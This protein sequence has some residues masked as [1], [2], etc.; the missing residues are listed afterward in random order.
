MRTQT[1]L[2]LSQLVTLC[3]GQKVGRPNILLFVVDDM[4]I[5]DVSWNNPSADTPNLG[6][7]ASNGIILENAYSLPT[8]APS[9]TAIL[10]GRY[11]FKMGLQRGFGTF[12]PEGIPLGVPLLP[13]YLQPRGYRN[14]NLGKWHLG[15][16]SEKY[17][18]I[19]RGFDTFDGLYV[20]MKQYKKVREMIKNK[21]QPMKL[22][23]RSGLL[24]DKVKKTRLVKNR[25][26]LESGYLKRT[27]FNTPVAKR[28]DESAMESK[29][30]SY[31]N[32]RSRPEEIQADYYVGKVKEILETHSDSDPFFIYLSF[33]TKFYN[34]FKEVNIKVDRPK[35]LKAMDEAVGQITDLLKIANLYNNTIIFFISDNGGRAMPDGVTSPNFPMKEF[36]GSVYEGG[37]KVPSFIHSPLLDGPGQRYEGLFHSV[38]VVPTLLNA[39]NISWNNSILDGIS[40]WT[41]FQEGTS[42]PRTHMVYNI[43]DEVVP[44]RLNLPE[45]NAAYQVKVGSSL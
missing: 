11:P 32:K 42:S 40:H 5:N 13:E 27:R 23:N 25:V 31:E 2:Y 24:K 36:K 6:S 21:K 8:C 38:D 30:A 9:R 29:Y 10:T 43:D 20:S 14:H 34:K 33:F 37:T 1:A 41:S 19:G 12:F 17:T 15:F 44:D 7:L 35:I 16:C 39:S 45:R 28:K 4:G 3:L 22:R 26:K 18:P